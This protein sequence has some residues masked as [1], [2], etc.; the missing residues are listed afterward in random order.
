MSAVAYEDKVTFATF[1]PKAA[2][3]K[4]AVTLLS[5]FF[6][7]VGVLEKCGFAPRTGLTINPKPSETKKTK[8]KQLLTFGES[9]LECEIR[10]LLK[11]M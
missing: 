8:V 2:A 4:F 6:V 11:L 3:S 9:F 7:I 5:E 10:Y 1:L